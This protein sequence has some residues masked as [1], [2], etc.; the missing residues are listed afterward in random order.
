M[1]WLICGILNKQINDQKQMTK[2][3]KTKNQTHRNRDQRDG[4]LCFIVRMFIK[5]SLSDVILAT[6]HFVK[7]K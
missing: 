3:N 6:Y 7:F 1:V 4:C 2:Q 5:K